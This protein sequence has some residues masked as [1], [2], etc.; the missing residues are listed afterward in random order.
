MYSYSCVCQHCQ[1]YLL[2]IVSRYIWGWS[3][4]SKEKPE[5]GFV[6]FYHYYLMI[7]ELI[8]FYNYFKIKAVTF[9]SIFLNIYYKQNISYQIYRNA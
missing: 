7:S 5:Q 6:H 4:H 9:I 2:V 8:Y 1:S 3:I